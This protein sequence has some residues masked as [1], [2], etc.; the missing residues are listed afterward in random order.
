MT[1]RV[2]TI[3]F[4]EDLSVPLE[5]EFFT[6]MNRTYKVE[7]YGKT[8]VVHVF[9]RDQ[10]RQRV[11]E[12]IY[13]FSPYFYG[14]MEELTWKDSSVSLI[15]D[16]LGRPNEKIILGLPKDTV[17]A[18][19][20]FDYHCGANIY[21]EDRWY[22]DSGIRVVYKKQ[23]DALVPADPDSVPIIPRRIMYFDIETLAPKEI[24]IEVV[25]GDPKYP[26]HMIQML[27]NYTIETTVY[28]IESPYWE[29]TVGDVIVWDG[30]DLPNG[31]H[32]PYLIRFIKCGTGIDDD[33]SIIFI[34]WG[35][36]LPTAL[37]DK[38]IEINIAVINENKREFELIKY[39]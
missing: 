9:A 4:D 18:R 26:I 17:K 19:K 11:H 24:P 7:D 3:R 33:E 36:L 15:P 22:W 39:E 14:G 34:E 2:S 8:P 31:V 38:R 23:G 20:R 10:N 12:K 16:I 28:Y 13:N 29:D 5:E 37:P 1:W 35:N 30:M 6:I 32:W 25:E 27:D 21:F